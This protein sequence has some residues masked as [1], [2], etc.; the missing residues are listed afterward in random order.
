MVEYR[1]ALTPLAE[2]YIWICNNHRESLS[3]FISKDEITSYI[4]QVLQNH[5]EQ[6]WYD[7]SDTQFEKLVSNFLPD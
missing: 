6:I 5:P 7:L 4:K 1:Y 3:E 2:A